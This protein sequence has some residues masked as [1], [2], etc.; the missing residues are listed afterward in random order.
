MA[1]FDSDQRFASG[2]FLALCLFAFATASVQ[3]QRKSPPESRENT[4]GIEMEDLGPVPKDKSN[5][6]VSEDGLHVAVITPSRTKQR[7]YYDG[8]AGPEFDEILHWGRGGAPAIRIA[9]NGAHVAYLARRGGRAFLCLD[10]NEI[11]VEVAGDEKGQQL[12]TFSPDSQ[13][14]VYLKMG[15]DGLWHVVFDNEPDPG[16]ND[17]VPPILFTA[18][19]A[20]YAYV[21]Q[22]D[23]GQ[24]VVLDG[25]A[26][27]PHQ[28]VGAL[29]FSPDGKHYAYQYTD[30]DKF[31]ASLD[32]KAG[33]SYDGV[34][35]DSVR[36]T[37]NGNLAYAAQKGAG[38]V[39]I[40]DGKERG[41]G[42]QM[43]QLQ[44]SSDG[45]RVAFVSTTSDGQTVVVDGKAGPAYEK[46]SSL[47]FSPD[48][49]RVAYIGELSTGKFVVV[50]EQESPPYR[51]V[52]NFQ[53]ASK[54]N[55]YGYVGST[56]KGAIVVVD[57]RASKTYRTFLDLAISSD[58]A[59]YAYEGDVDL[60]VAELVIDGKV[61]RARN[62]VATLEPDRSAT[63]KKILQF[64]P[65]SKR[66]AMASMVSGGAK[67]VITVDG[68][69]GP[70]SGWCYRF[71]FSP[72]GS[73]FAYVTREPIRGIWNNVAVTLD[74]KIVQLLP[75][76]P[77]GDITLIAQ[78][79]ED[80][81]NPGIKRVN[82]N[83]FQ[84]R[85]DGKLKYLALKDGKIMRI[86]ITPGAAAPAA[87][88]KTKEGTASSN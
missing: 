19:G 40:V 58:G 76:P 48:G 3:A 69:E 80:S 26:A 8:Q 12:F 46:I 63:H 2:G 11:E 70:T 41:E 45:K 9:R 36:F 82:P 55:R 25:K 27:P 38:Y 57:G 64:S 7:V 83:Y 85:E 74:R 22:S 24:S 77:E 14:L 62:L 21:A 81:T 86:S 73:H 47:M 18:D 33:A 35:P 37:A 39:A 32:G 49:V 56:E 87:Q 10:D 29:Q 61:A 20:H 13:H 43:E 30:G 79:V 54:G 42:Q 50:D 66:L 23:K 28:N 84:F 60:Y 17:I 59:R 75:T 71:A 44:I 52:S 16:F 5:M 68:I 15:E 51:S 88:E 31:V 34:Q 53:F 6:C 67:Y 65:D 1:R 72:D 4:S 78:A